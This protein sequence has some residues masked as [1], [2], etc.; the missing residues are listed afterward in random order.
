MIDHDKLRSLVKKLYA[1]VEELELMFPGRHFTP[2][3][4]MVGSLGECLVAD[5]YGLTLK[6][7][8]NKGY[9][10][11]TPSG[12]PVEI[13]AT[14]SSIA[15]FRSV[16]Q[17]AIVIKI[18]PNGTFKEVF[19]G[20]GKPYIE[21]QFKRKASNGQFQISLKKLD[22]LNKLVPSEDQLQVVR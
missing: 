10:A 14:Q 18:L 7:A 4:H 20:P 2:D 5:A 6:A 16:P 13:K 3:G 21:E 1:V 12:M 17:H 19:N 15:S 9:D 8:S 11:V 22:E